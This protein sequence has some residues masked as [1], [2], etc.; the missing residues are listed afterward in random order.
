[1]GAPLEDSAAQG[2]GGDETNNASSGTG[3][4]YTFSRTGSTWTQQAY[5]KA[6]NTEPYPPLPGWADV[7]GSSVA[8]SADG[9]LLAVGA[10]GEGSFRTGVGS[11]AYVLEG[12][13]TDIGAAYTFKRAGVTWTQEAYIKSSR[14]GQD[15][16]GSKRCRVGRR[17]HD[18]GW[19]LAGRQQRNRHQRRRSGHQR[20]QQRRGIRLHCAVANASSRVVKVEFL[21]RGFGYDYGICCWSAHKAP[22]VRCASP[23]KP[24]LRIAF[25]STRES[26]EE[27]V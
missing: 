26:H 15:Q 12:Q 18:C 6:S 5:V 1:V 3:A 25:A 4:V 2:I 23:G 19:S 9:N 16:F 13:T 11:G 10:W 7:F 20:S 14:V 8:L 27:L 17:K 22:A 24:D 21:R